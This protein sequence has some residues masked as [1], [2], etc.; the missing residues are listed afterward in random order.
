M[1]LRSF[2]IP[3]FAL[4]SAICTQAVELNTAKATPLK[5]NDIEV[6]VNEQSQTLWLNI[7]LDMADMKLPADREMIFTP[8][9]IAENGTDSLELDPITVAGRNRWYWHLRNSDLDAPGTYV[10]RAGSTTHAT[11]KERIPFEPWMGNSLIEMRQE[12]A[13]CCDRP[14]P[15]PGP[16]RRGNVDLALID[17]RRPPLIAEFVFAPPVDAG[18]VIK[19]LK[20]S[21]FITFVVNRTE[22]KPD[23]MINPQELRKIYNSIQY[24]KDD[25]DATITH[26]HI[27]G[28][29]SPEGPYDNNVRLARGRTQTL[30]EYVRNLYA[31]P[32]SLIATD[33]EPEDWEGLERYVAQSDMKERDALL[34]IIRSDLAPDA[35]DW[36][37]KKRYPEQYA[38]LLREVYPALRHSD[39]TV[40]YEVRAYTDIDEIRRLLRTAPQKLSLEEIYLAAQQMEPGTDEHTEAFEIAVRMFPED[41]VANLN[42]ANTALS[43]GD[44]EYAR[45]YLERAGRTA[46]AVYARGVLAALGGEFETALSLFGTARDMGCASACGQLAQIENILE[47]R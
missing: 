38:F 46:E 24:V 20:G 17:T 32:D 18:P 1:T 6:E 15:L 47:K 4:A 23:Y 19:E 27:K 14:D 35:R 8:V 31:F 33:F 36:R 21:A 45:R 2:I 29:A 7:D 12:A 42:A 44:L 39:Y 37:L 11:Y 41:P 3:A 10:Y 43:R 9:I 13:T 28:F 22:L 25:K 30:K 5:V 16:G 40:R 26:V 34:E